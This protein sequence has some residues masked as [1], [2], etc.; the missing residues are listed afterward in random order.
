M[1]NLIMRWMSSEFVEIEIGFHEQS[2]L[3]D[4]R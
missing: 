4:E 1:K 2:D 3:A